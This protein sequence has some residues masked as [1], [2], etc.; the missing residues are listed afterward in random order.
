MSIKFEDKGRGVHVGFFTQSTSGGRSVPRA[1]RI[2]RERDGF[3]ADS[4]VAMAGA[5]LPWGAVTAEVFPTFEAA[6][7][8]LQ[9]KVAGNQVD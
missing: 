6:E 1:V 7:K 5:W 2:V 8:F 9:E 3:R 4:T